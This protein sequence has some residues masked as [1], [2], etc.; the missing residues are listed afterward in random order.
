MDRSLDGR[1]ILI[2][3]DEPLVALDI[4]YAFQA[5]GAHIIMERTLPSA[6]L[7]AENSGLSAAILDHGLGDGDSSQ[8]C[9]RLTERGIPFVVHTGYSEVDGVC[10]SGVHIGKPADPQVL[11]TAVEGLLRVR[12]PAS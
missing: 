9:K 12:A 4:A 6:L 1:S 7:A 11:V 8:L 10:S 5:A 2:V 3:E